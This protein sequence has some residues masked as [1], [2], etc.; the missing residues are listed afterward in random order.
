MTGTGN[1]RGE[2]VHT[3]WDYH[4][5]TKPTISGD[6]SDGLLHDVESKWTF[7]NVLSSH[8]TQATNFSQ[9]LEF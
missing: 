7:W 9:V 5:H 6:V 2:T 3:F 1:V 8:F 4:A